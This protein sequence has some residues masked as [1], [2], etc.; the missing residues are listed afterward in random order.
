MHLQGP[1]FAFT[2]YNGMTERRRLTSKI[3]DHLAQRTDWVMMALKHNALK[4]IRFE[5]I[6]EHMRRPE[7][8]AGERQYFLVRCDHA[9][10]SEQ[11][12][13]TVG[14]VENQEYRRAGTFE[15][16]D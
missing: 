6:V 5:D 12:K 8:E 3:K 15:V 13:L 1:P 7:Q 14:F 11:S 4:T 9:E 16:F 2:E 10:R